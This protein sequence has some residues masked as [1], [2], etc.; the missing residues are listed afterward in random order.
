ISLSTEPK[1]VVCSS[2]KFGG[3]FHL[4]A[5]IHVDRHE[6]VFERG[7]R[8]AFPN[9][10]LSESLQRCCSNPHHIG[11]FINGVCAVVPKMGDR[12]RTVCRTRVLISQIHQTARECLTQRCIKSRLFVSAWRK[13]L[14]SIS[15]RDLVPL[16]NAPSISVRQIRNAVGA[17]NCPRSRV[18][19]HRRSCY[20]TSCVV[21]LKAKR[22]AHLMRRKLTKSREHHFQELW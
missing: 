12:T 11:Q 22:V 6:N 5:V 2:D 10:V 15:N 3:G 9:V 13:V 7:H 16:P 1:R 14:I 8:C 21:V 18:S 20:R 17:H 19:H 4:I